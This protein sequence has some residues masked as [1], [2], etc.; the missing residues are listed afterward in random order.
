MKKILSLLLIALL[1]TSCPAESYGYV[2]LFLERDRKAPRLLDYDLKENRICI[3]TFD[4]TVS[5]TDAR[6]DGCTVY[7]SGS[8]TRM[9]MLTLSREIQPGKAETLFFSAEDKAGNTSRFALKLVGINLTQAPLIITEV[10][11]KGT[12]QAPDRIE[13][14]ATG[15]GSTGGYAVLDG[16]IGYENHAF[17]LPD[18]MMNKNDIIVIYW[19]KCDALPPT[20]IRDME[21]TYYLFAESDE[22]LIGTN[23]GV[24]LY[25][26]TNGKGKV[27]DAFLYNTSDATNN[28][29]YG[30]E[31]SEESVRYLSSIGEW[32]GETFRSDY[33]TSSRVAA[34]YYPYQ[35][36]DSAS[37][38]YVTAPRMSTFGYP[39]T[40]VIYEP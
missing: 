19:D 27:E 39:N 34:R 32:S 35:D 26:H 31:A 18:I 11:M 33:V 25:S 40:N 7:R 10:S 4:E 14:T 28:N 23:G 38:F 21:K 6:M 16:I 24:I 17:H 29:G 8:M 15:S 22:T 12:S 5:I 1:L 3:L 20:L 9:A 2:N 13:L 30:N 36:T 37:D